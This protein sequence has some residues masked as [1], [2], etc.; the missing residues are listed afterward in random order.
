MSDQMAA[1]KLI[2]STKA[3]DI[4]VSLGRRNGPARLMAAGGAVMVL[5][6]GLGVGA[7]IGN[8]APMAPGVPAVD[9]APVATETIVVEMAYEPGESSGWHVH[10]IN[11]I[12]E[13]R[14]GELAVYD[15]AC[16]LR[17]YGPGETYVGGTQTHLIRNEGF[18]P[19]A[20]TVKRVETPDAT[21]S[22]LRE[23]APAGCPIG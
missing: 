7:L 11:H 22:V 9:A 23:A 4:A 1:A 18:V 13:V 21:Y 16:Q 14:S 20:M 10:P 2:Q 12:V 15:G 5:A 6:A 19:V 8:G 17:T 3:A